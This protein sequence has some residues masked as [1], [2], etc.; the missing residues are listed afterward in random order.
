MPLRADNA[1]GCIPLTG[2]DTI[3]SLH[4]EMATEPLLRRWINRKAKTGRE[5]R[6][7]RER[8]ARACRVGHTNVKHWYSGARPIP[9]KH[10]LPIQKETRGGIKATEILEAGA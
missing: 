10:A 2:T 5:R 6:A 3:C 8:I 4:V 1:T 9:A 7:L